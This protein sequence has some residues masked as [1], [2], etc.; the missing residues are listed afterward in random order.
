M[1]P[2]GSLG[3]G[4]YHCKLTELSNP[5]LGVVWGGET[6]KPNFKST[7]THLKKYSSEK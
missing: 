5:I 6:H 3:I 1:A 4:M 7:Q 2:S